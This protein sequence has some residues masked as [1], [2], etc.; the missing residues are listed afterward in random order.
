LLPMY[1]LCALL[2]LANSHDTTV[3]VL[4][5]VLEEH[6]EALNN[7]P[8]YLWKH[9]YVTANRKTKTRPDAEDQQPMVRLGRNIGQMFRKFSGYKL[10][11]TQ[12]GPQ[13]RKSKLNPKG[14]QRRYKWQLMLC[15][16]WPLIPDIIRAVTLQS[17]LPET[18]SVNLTEAQDAAA[19]DSALELD[20][21]GTDSED[22]CE[23]QTSCRNKSKKMRI[24]S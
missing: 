21:E 10:E 22:D 8:R 12:D 15:P 16:E 19:E 5:S 11:G 2:G 1:N 3:V 23:E 20:W 18:V 6:E 7:N 14:G 24:S 13:P 9:K 4:Q 17:G